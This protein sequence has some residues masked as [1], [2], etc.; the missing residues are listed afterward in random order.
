VTKYSAS[1]INI[2]RYNFLLQKEKIRITLLSRTTKYR[3]ILNEDEVCMRKYR[4]F[5]INIAT[6]NVSK[7]VCKKKI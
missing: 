2:V 7:I 1:S 4:F 6:Y 3:K 5:F